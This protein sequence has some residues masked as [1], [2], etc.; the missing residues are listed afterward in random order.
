MIMM[1][2]KEGECKLR[3]QR[4]I[5]SYVSDAYHHLLFDFTSFVYHVKSMPPLAS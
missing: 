4:D 2:L 5:N 1:V 3:A